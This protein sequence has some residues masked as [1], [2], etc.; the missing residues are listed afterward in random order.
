MIYDYVDLFYKLNACFNPLFNPVF[1]SMLFLAS[2][3][4]SHFIQLLR[5]SSQKYAS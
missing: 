5:E 1:L 2:T 3:N 4:N